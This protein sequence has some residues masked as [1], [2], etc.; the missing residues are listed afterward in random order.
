M[1]EFRKITEE[2]FEA[3]MAL[4]V[5]EN[6]KS[7]VAENLKSLAQAYLAASNHSCTPIPFALY[8]NDTPVGFIMMAYHSAPAA[9]DPGELFHESIYEIWRLMID[10]HFQGKGYGRQALEKAIAYIH[11]YPFGES[12]KIVLSYEP[13]NLTA[14]HLYASVGFV[15]SGDIFDNE[16]IAVLDL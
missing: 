10:K 6:Q 7:F 4:E 12:K 11:T 8:D 16:I 15:E 3:C 2:N 14:K 13:E 9:D 1:V 5:H